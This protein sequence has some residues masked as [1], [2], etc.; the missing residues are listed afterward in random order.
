[1]LNNV[2]TVSVELIDIKNNKGYEGKNWGDKIGSDLWW[3][4]KAVGR[5]SQSFEE[6][7]EGQSDGALPQSSKLSPVQPHWPF[8]F[9]NTPDSFLLIFC[10]LCL[11]CCLPLL[12]YTWC[13]LTSQM[14][15]PQCEL[16]SCHY[17]QGSLPSTRFIISH[18][19][20]IIT[21]WN[22]LVYS[23][24]VSYTIEKALRNG[25]SV[26]TILSSSG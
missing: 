24:V 23:S 22:E 14:P 12:F 11:R 1:M 21:I 15:S 10:F 17:L 26:L 5:S 6:L 20:F 13:L 2:D 3:R 19:L 18:I 4:S 8:L 25:E 9:S 16:P 7:R